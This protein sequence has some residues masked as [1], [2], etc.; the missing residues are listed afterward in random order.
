TCLLLAIREEMKVS[1][2]DYKAT[3]PVPP[4]WSAP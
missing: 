2:A 3:I 4:C 1:P